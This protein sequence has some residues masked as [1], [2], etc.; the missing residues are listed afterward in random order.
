VRRGKKHGPDQVMRVFLVDDH[1]VVRMGTRSLIEAEDD[2]TVVGEAATAEECLAGLDEKQTDV[3]VLDMRLPDMNG[4]ELCHAISARHPDVKLVVLTAFADEW[5]LIGSFLAGASAFV[6]KSVKG[7][8]LIEAIRHA[9]AGERF[10]DPETEQRIHSRIGAKTDDL[11]AKLSPQE[12]S[13]AHLLARGM[14]NREIAREMRLAEKTVK[15]YVSNLLAK[16][17]MRRRSQAAAYVAQVEAVV[18]QP[19]QAESWDELSSALVDGLA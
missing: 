14:T 9:S 13:V 12:R 8:D 6:L 5:A 2:M 4:V 3:V 11:M 1:G 17:G 10:V 15:N 19:T 18:A 16:M 7:D